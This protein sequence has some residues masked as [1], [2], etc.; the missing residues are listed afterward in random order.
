M[1]SYS[2]WQKEIDNAQRVATP[3]FII[4]RA[5]STKKKTREKDEVITKE[6]EVEIK[7]GIAV[8]TKEE[9]EINDEDIKMDSESKKDDIIKAQ[10]QQIKE[11]EKDI[12]NLKSDAELLHQVIEKR[13]KF[14]LPLNLYQSFWV[15]Y[16][17][18]I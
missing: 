18:N 5:F 9:S 8:E 16:T 10:A 17:L 4:L 3:C 15:P 11:L 12:D 2:G 7:D 13:K 6:A 14:C 1:W